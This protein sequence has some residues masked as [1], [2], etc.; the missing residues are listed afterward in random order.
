MPQDGP[1]HVQAELPTEPSRRIVAELVRMPVSYR[2]SLTSLRLSVRPRYSVL[3]SPTVRID[4][5]PIPGSFPGLASPS[6]SLGGLNASFAILALFG[7][8]LGLRVGR[9]EQVGRQLGTE[10]RPKGLL[11]FRAEID[12]PLPA[13]MFCLVT[14]GSVDPNAARPIDVDSPHGANL[15]GPHSREALE[16]NHRPDL[17]GD[18]RRDCLNKRIRDRP[19]RLGLSDVGPAPTETRNRFQAVMDRRRDHFLPDGP[20]KLSLAFGGVYDQYTREGS[21]L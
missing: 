8:P 6:V 9:G 12:P 2:S 15:P 11:S 3:N 1:G 10:P 21:N 5:I 18:V 4:G 17:T 14:L 19:D 16:F 7:S 20:F 13:V